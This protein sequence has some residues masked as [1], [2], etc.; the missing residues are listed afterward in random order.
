VTLFK[1]D[2]N[3]QLDHNVYILLCQFTSNTE[4][5]IVEQTTM[6]TNRAI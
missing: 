6:Y 1:L 3:A 2:H 5:V 4:S